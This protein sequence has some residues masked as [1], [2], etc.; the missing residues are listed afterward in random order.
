MQQTIAAIKDRLAAIYA[1]AE[2]NLISE[3][4]F[5]SVS[6]MNRVQFLLNKNVILSESIRHEVDLILNRLSKHEPIQ[7]I[8]GKTDFY[9]LTFGVNKNVLIPRAETSEII[10]HILS[11][12][13]SFPEQCRCLDIGTGSGCIPIVLKKNCP[14]WQISAIDI[15]S[16]ALKVAQENAIRNEVVINFREADILNHQAL[17]FVQK[18]DL[19]ISN[20][21]Y[22]CEEEK[23]EMEA[24]V[25]DYEPHQALFVP[26]DNPLLFYRSIA[27]FATRNLTR[28]GK[29]IFEINPKFASEL[30]QLLEEKRFS[31]ICVLKDIS[32]KKRFVIG[33]MQ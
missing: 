24:N 6:G 28:G 9:G 27:E 12:K 13:T 1:P 29:L 7:Y 2:I 33:K 16:D 30:C 15:S 17:H 32:E 4:I 3:M 14:L 19:I 23:S 11:E 8:L 18:F 26:N 10:E 31:H 21:P 25:L 5:E 20:P 22:I